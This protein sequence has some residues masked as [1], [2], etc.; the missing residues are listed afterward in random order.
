LLVYNTVSV[1]SIVCC[2]D[3]TNGLLRSISAHLG[4]WVKFGVKEW[5]P[6]VWVN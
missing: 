2:I 6:I 4:L 3:Q 5:T 1:S